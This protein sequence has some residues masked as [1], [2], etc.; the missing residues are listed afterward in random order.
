MTG[1]VNVGYTVPIEPS[2]AANVFDS[3][4]IEACVI[5]IDFALSAS[6]GFAP[7]ATSE[8]RHSAHFATIEA[9]R[10]TFLNRKAAIVDSCAKRS[11]SST[12]KREFGAGKPA[13]R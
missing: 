7:D 5:N 8:S 2:S 1:V 3:A 13:L 11:V 9:N 6:V 12:G 10:G 4:E